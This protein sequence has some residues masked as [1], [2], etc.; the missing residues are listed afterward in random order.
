LVASIVLLGLL[1]AVQWYQG[2][3]AMIVGRLLKNRTVLV[4]MVAVFFIGGGFFLLLYYLP[5]Y[6][7][8]VS[9]VTASQSGVRNLPLIISS[10]IATILSGGL[11]SG[12]GHFVPLA[13]LGTA[14]GTVGNGLLY[15]LGVGSSAGQWIGYQVV[16]GLGLGLAFQIPI[17]ST[18]A[19]V[20]PEDLA[21]ATAMI[22]FVQAFG[23]AYLIAAGEAAF[24]NTVIRKVPEYVPGLDGHDVIHAGIANLRRVFEGDALEGVIHAYMDALKIDYAIAI[25]CAAIAFIAWFGSEWPWKNLKGKVNVSAA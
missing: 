2:E 24:A 23:G 7:Q 19:T 6:F 17:I 21:S 4:G 15:S 18:Q 22:L 1:V 14:I 12:F 16:T 10:T 9:G 3:R 20:A 5:L 25:A 13:I 8:V 11:I